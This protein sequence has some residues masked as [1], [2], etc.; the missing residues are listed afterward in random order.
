MERWTH[1]PSSLRLHPGLP[2]GGRERAGHP[3]P[4]PERPR[5]GTTTRG[6]GATTPPSACRSTGGSTHR[7]AN[8][9]TLPWRGTTWS[10]ASTNPLKLSS[11]ERPAT[12]ATARRWG[13]TCAGRMGN[14]AGRTLRADA[15]CSHTARQPRGGLRPRGRGTPP[16]SGCG[17]WKT[18]LGGCRL[19]SDR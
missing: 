2:G 8:T 18:R 14:S 7:A 10:A 6:S 12:G 11:W 16:W 17:N 1:G 19:D 13:W 9:T 4:H 5:G 3:E 15:T